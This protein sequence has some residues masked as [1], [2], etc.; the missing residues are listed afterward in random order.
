VTGLD[1]VVLD[2]AANSVL[3]AKQSSQLDLW[4]FVDEIGS[5]TIRV[6]DGCLIADQPNARVSKCRMAFF[7]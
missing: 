3:R 4:V 5:V 6:I 7:K 1:H 2:V